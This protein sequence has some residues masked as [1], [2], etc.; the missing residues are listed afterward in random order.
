MPKPIKMIPPAPPV[1]TESEI[2]TT[3]F[4][5]PK[6]DFEKF[7]LPPEKI[8]LPKLD[9]KKDTPAEPEIETEQ[10]KKLY[11]PKKYSSGTSSNNAKTTD[12]SYTGS[13]G[14]EYWAD[15]NPNYALSKTGKAQSPINLQDA[16]PKVGAPLEFLYRPSKINLVNNGHTIQQN[17]DRGS[18]VLY[19]GKS[20]HLKYI[21]FHSK[22]E[23][24][25]CNTYSMLEMQLVHES[26][27]G[28]KL[29][30]GILYDIGD[31]NRFLASFF[32]NLPQSAQQTYRSDD[33]M[34]VSIALPT[35]RSMFH[36]TGSLT[37]PPT[38]EGVNW[39]VFADVQSISEN[40][41][42]Q[43][44]SLHQNNY[45]PIQNRNDREVFLYTPIQ[46]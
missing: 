33:I 5:A 23:H 16:E 29:I 43:F 12:W 30:V 9:L 13:T 2:D 36:Y 42:E 17:Y 26:D 14:P 6:D 7:K 35:R 37:T 41:L 40:Q 31:E 39:F 27:S 11:E 46:K 4:N 44:T 15:I 21:D 25:M 8:D 28:E 38:T 18:Y 34:N 1:E 3:D 20:Y 24:T 19:K 32:G 10:P 22:S 45:R